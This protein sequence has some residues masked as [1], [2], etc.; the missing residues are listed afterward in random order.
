MFNLTIKLLYGIC[1][2]CKIVDEYK[3]STA[4]YF[5]SHRRGAKNTEKCWKMPIIN[6]GALC[7]SSERRERA[8]NKQAAII[9][10]DAVVMAI[11]NK[12]NHRNAGRSIDCD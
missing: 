7:L 9:P 10:A 1:S 2:I 4:I 5:Q 3:R 8:V 11:K 12:T 6:L